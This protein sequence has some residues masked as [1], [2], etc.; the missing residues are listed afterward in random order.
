MLTKQTKHSHKQPAF[1]RLDQNTFFD[2]KAFCS[3]RENGS[4]S[5][6]NTN[7][8]HFDTSLLVGNNWPMVFQAA[9]PR[10]HRLCHR[11]RCALGLHMHPE[12]SRESCCKLQKAIRSPD[13]NMHTS[14]LCAPHRCLI[15]K[16]HMGILDC[17]QSQCSS[18]ASCHKRRS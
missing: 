4:H 2:P 7:Y 3:N 6:G 16:D 14:P 15:R 13:R 10:E 11:Q 17:C 8:F 12:N 18:Q 5:G 1:Q 9:G